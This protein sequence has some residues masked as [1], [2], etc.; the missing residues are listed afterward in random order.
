MSKPF[1]NKPSL[2]AST[3]L[4]GLLVAPT[5]FAADMAPLRR[6]SSTFMSS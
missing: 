6:L 3:T 1:V 4:A 5:A 2:L